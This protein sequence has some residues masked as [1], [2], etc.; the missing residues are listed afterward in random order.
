MGNMEIQHKKYENH[1]IISGE[2]IGRFNMGSTIVLIV[3][4]G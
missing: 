4:L 2:E 3:E 1:K